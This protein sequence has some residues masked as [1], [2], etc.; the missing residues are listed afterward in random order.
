MYAC[1]RKCRA[2]ISFWLTRIVFP[3]DLRQFINSITSSSWDIADCKNSIGFSGTKDIR[4]IF[5]AQLSWVPSQD[6][7][8]RGTDGKNI[9]FLLT[10]VK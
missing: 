6:D 3:V 5:P 1:F 10:Q 8:I 2:T 9:S 7:E 4:W